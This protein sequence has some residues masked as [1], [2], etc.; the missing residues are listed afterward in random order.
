[1]SRSVVVTVEKAKLT[2]T[3]KAWCQRG[4][5]MSF[6]TTNSSNLANNGVEFGIDFEYEGL[7]NGTEKGLKRGD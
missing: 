1:M 4:R 6:T 3:L 2:M 7:K 5:A